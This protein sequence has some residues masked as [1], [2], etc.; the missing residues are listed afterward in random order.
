MRKTALLITLIAAV[1][2]A[3]P[4]VAQPAAAPASFEQVKEWVDRYKA[5]HAGNRGKDWDI[6]AKTPA[7]IAADPDAQRLLS[8]CGADERPII[9]LLAWEYGGSDHRWI[10]P[11]RSALVYCVYTPVRTASPHWRYDRTKD[12]VTVDVYVK[13]PEQNPCKGERGA[14][15]VAACI[16]DRTNFEILVD[17]A[18]LNDGRDAGLSLASASTTLNLLLPD[19]TRT[20]L[21]IDR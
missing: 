8:L 1:V 16:G 3:R 15:Q 2:L 20:Q 9:P 17:T 13:F 19:G 12:E 10:N 14:N 7:Q 18:S 4:A 5:S 6:N 11:N 21:W